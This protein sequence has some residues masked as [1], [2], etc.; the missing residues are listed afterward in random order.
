MKLPLDFDIQHYRLLWIIYNHPDGLSGKQLV[1]ELKQRGWCDAATTAEDLGLAPE[2][3]V[4]RPRVA[5]NDP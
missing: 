2:D 3:V 1:E 5:I 4:C